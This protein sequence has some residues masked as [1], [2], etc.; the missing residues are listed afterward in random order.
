MCPLPSQLLNYL[1]PKWTLKLYLCTTKLEPLFRYFHFMFLLNNKL[2]SITGNV[3]KHNKK[4]KFQTPGINYYIVSKFYKRKLNN[5]KLFFRI[6]QTTLWWLVF[7]TFTQNSTIAF[8][9]KNRLLFIPPV[10]YAPFFSVNQLPQLEPKKSI[11]ENLN[12]DCN[13]IQSTHNQKS[14]L[15]HNKIWYAWCKM[16]LND[17]A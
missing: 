4:V 17:L 16:S 2:F 11:Y 9:L 8:W 1:P 13:E 12:I 7:A 3:C 14:L 10:F 15:I 6:C 5:F